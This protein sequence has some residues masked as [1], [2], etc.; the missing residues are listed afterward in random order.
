LAI[1][2]KKGHVPSLRWEEVAQFWRDIAGHSAVM[3]HQTH[4]AI[5]LQALTFVRPGELIA[6]RW[7]EIDTARGWWVIPATRMKKGK[8]HIVPLSQEAMQILKY[9]KLISG[10]DTYVFSSNR[11]KSGHIS[12]MTINMVLNRIG[13]KGRMCAHGFRAVAMTALQEEQGV[14]RIVIDRQLAHVPETKIAA[15]YNRAEYI[16]ERTALMQTW[17]EMHVKAGMPLPQ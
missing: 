7:D 3:D 14:D 8:E 9:Q 17:A 15:A 4:N 1:K 5:R 13:Y 2:S 10:Q 11:S 6:M 12:N 16:K